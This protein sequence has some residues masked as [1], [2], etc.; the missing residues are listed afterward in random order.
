MFN[1][2]KSWPLNT[3]FFTILY[4]RIGKLHN[5]LSLPTEIGWLSQGKALA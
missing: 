3:H 4:D 2:I 1:P 5:P